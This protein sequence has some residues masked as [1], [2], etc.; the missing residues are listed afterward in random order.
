MRVLKGP[1]FQL[2][3]TQALL[4]LVALAAHTVST[5]PNRLAFNPDASKAPVSLHQLQGDWHQEYSVGVDARCS[6]VSMAFQPN[7]DHSHSML[8]TASC[9]VPAGNHNSEAVFAKASQNSF[10]VIAKSYI[11]TTLNLHNSVTKENTELRVL[12]ADRVHYN[13]LILGDPQ[14]KIVRIMIRSGF[15]N[16]QTKHEIKQGLKA[17]N[18]LGHAKTQE[19]NAPLSSFQGSSY[20]SH[21]RL[22]QTQVVG[23]QNGG[24]RTMATLKDFSEVS[25]KS[26]LK[27]VSYG[28]QPKD[29]V[30]T[31]PDPILPTPT[32][33]DFQCTPQIPKTPTVS[34]NIGTKCATPIMRRAKLGD[35][36]VY[37]ECPPNQRPFIT[38]PDFNYM[39]ELINK[40][41]KLNQTSYVIQQQGKKIVTVE[42]KDTKISFTAMKP[43]QQTAKIRD[44]EPVGEIKGYSDSQVEF[45]NKKTETEIRINQTHWR[46]L[47]EPFITKRIGLVTRPVKIYYSINKTENS[48]TVDKDTNILTTQLIWSPL[49]VPTQTQKIKD[50]LTEATIT[51]FFDTQKTYD[52]KKIE[53]LVNTTALHWT[54]LK[55]P[56]CAKRILPVT[57]VVRI[58]SHKIVVEYANSKDKV[59]E[60]KTDT[61]T[62]SVMTE[63]LCK[64]KIKDISSI[65]V[66]KWTEDYKVVVTATST[67]VEQTTNKWVQSLITRFP[68]CKCL[69]LQ[70]SRIPTK[71]FV[72]AIWSEADWN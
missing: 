52:N 3:L 48:S 32:K 37:P 50:I 4:G 53:I 62:W 67:E 65:V 18:G 70:Q 57:R 43:P 24:S 25:T 69:P 19:C 64:T 60:I 5:A 12:N 14:K 28:V 56:N 8:L 16:I 39:A 29:K 51:G 31:S 1:T 63:P 38:K 59:Q 36:I 68:D 22:L 6:C 55:P 47:S 9:A 49:K 15:A 7:P 58:D 10:V 26:N 13:W 33:P 27:P 44:I 71:A 72:G 20:V 46:P 17:V 30:C 40:V 23:C 35:V 54:P 61:A 42:L 11:Q 41:I 34:K 66:K 45:C 21:H 2:S